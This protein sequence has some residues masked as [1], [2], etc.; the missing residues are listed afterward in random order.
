MVSLVLDGSAST[1]LIP[2]TSILPQLPVFP[3][4]SRLLARC[5]QE[6]TPNSHQSPNIH[7][8]QR[9]RHGKPTHLDGDPND[10]QIAPN[11]QWN[12]H[13]KEHEEHLGLGHLK[14]SVA[15]GEEAPGIANAEFLRLSPVAI[16]AEPEQRGVEISAVIN[17]RR[18]C[19]CAEE[20]VEA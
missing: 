16:L 6:D 12:D 8:C 5:I 20:F 18:I 3:L 17:C 11:K 1:M 13:E 15:G 4:I 7:S 14:T 10:E 19:T 2:P 9:H